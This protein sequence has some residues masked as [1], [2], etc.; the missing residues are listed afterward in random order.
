MYNEVMLQSII[1]EN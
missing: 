1:F